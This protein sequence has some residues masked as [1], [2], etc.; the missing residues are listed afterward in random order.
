MEGGPGEVRCPR[1][2]HVARLN[3]WRWTN[4][5]FVVGFLGFTFWDWPLLTESYSDSRFARLQS[6]DLQFCRWRKADSHTEPRLA[7][8]CDGHC[9][10]TE[11][12]PWGVAV[13]VVEVHLTEREIDVLCLLAAGNTSLQAAGMLRLS[14]RTV[15]GHV[16]AMLRK[17]GLRNRA[18]LLALAVANDIIDMS[19]TPP[20][21]TGRT[22]LPLSGDAG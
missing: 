6:C 9:V 5:P 10:L 17:A 8:S 19:A 20:T 11:K 22:G 2:R 16:A 7:V 18:E 3:D 15:D 1:F 12:N 4:E 13:T 21:W 14:K